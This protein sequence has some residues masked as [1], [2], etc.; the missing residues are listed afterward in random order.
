MT[1][2]PH[3]KLII[4][5]AASLGLLAAGVYVLITVDWSTNQPLVAA[6]TGWI[7]LVMGYWLR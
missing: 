5:G 3:D 2:N 4:Q 1:P 6:A 7:G